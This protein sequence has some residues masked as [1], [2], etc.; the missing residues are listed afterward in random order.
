VSSEQQGVP[1]DIACQH[2][3]EI[4][5]DYLEGALDPETTAAVEYHLTLCAGC[6]EY[7]DQMRT[8]IRLVGHVPVDSLPATVR[9]ELVAAFR[10]FHAG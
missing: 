4:V 5:T 7:I 6:S 9:D 2:L 8:T 1:D 10:D 3:V